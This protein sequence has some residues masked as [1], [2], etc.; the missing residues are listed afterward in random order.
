MDFVPG[1]LA[2]MR[3]SF[4]VAPQRSP[5]H[6]SLL[7]FQAGHNG[8]HHNGK[9]VEGRVSLVWGD[10]IRI[11]NTLLVF[12]EAAAPAPPEGNPCP[13]SDLVGVGPAMERVRYPSLA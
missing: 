1:M 12:T 3:S 2:R 7:A 5:L 4:H 13:E 11:G 6:P 10:V 8:T 9:P